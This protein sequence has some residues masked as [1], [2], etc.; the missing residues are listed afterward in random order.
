MLLKAPP[1]GNEQED[2][3]QQKDIYLRH[4]KHP[5]HAITQDRKSEGD[6]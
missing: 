2:P 3:N 5:D 1:T 6:Q 4:A